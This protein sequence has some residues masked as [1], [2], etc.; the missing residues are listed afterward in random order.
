MKIKKTALPEQ[1]KPQSIS[2]DCGVHLATIDDLFEG[3]GS[4]TSGL[5]LEEVNRRHILYGT[6]EL[7]VKQ[8]V[9]LYIRYLQQFKNFFALLLIF[10]GSLAVLAEFLDPGEGNIY[11]AIALFV[12]VILNATFTFFQ[13]FQSE[14]IMDR[15]VIILH[16]CFGDTLNVNL[17]KNLFLIII[18]C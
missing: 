9:P 6:N 18:F 3:I 15:Y 7:R 12:V 17:T 10:G 13:E 1:I 4:S 2:I 8:D 16:Y 5:S 14:R 11:I